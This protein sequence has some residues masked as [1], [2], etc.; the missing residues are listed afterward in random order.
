MQGLAI[1]TSF[2]DACIQ[3]KDVET[4]LESPIGRSMTPPPFGLVSKVIERDERIVELE[5][6]IEELGVEE[7]E[8]EIERRRGEEAFEGIK[9]ELR[10]TNELVDRLKLELNDANASSFEHS[11][12]E[13]VRI[14]ELEEE[15]QKVYKTV[16]G[17]RTELLEAVGAEVFGLMHVSR[18]LSSL[19]IMKERRCR[20]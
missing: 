7:N 10:D 1:C 20:S 6:R 8:Y 3:T 15:L 9:L 5:K 17:L 11:V 14:K 13:K 2:E 4:E 19:V 16:E 18:S 12:V